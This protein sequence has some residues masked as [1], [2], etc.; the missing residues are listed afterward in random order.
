VDVG[1]EDDFL[2]KG[3]LEPDALVKAAETAKRAKG[4]VEVRMQEGFDHS[5]YFVSVM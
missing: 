3:Q 4:E 5:Y 1:T 2:K